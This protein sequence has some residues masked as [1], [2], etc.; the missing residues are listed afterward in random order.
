MRYA[1]AAVKLRKAGLDLRE[2]HQP[3]D[4]VIDGRIRSQLP[5][6]LDHRIARDSYGH[7]A[8]TLTPILQPRI[9]LVGPTSRDEPRRATTHQAPGSIALLARGS[10]FCRKAL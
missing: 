3:F 4:R 7:A 1:F 5:N 9:R 2:E 10:E 8:S 6:G